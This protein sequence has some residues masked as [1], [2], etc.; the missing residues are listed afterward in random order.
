[1]LQS[2]EILGN[3]VEEI[4]ESRV[5]VT[6][7]R[8]RYYRELQFPTRPTSPDCGPTNGGLT[9]NGTIFLVESVIAGLIPT[10]GDQLNE[11]IYL[12]PLLVM[13]AIHWCMQSLGDSIALDAGNLLYLGQVGLP[14]WILTSVE[15]TR[16]KDGDLKGGAICDIGAFEY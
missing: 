6:P 11:Y 13:A 12:H 5:K 8:T 16:P 10:D 2:Q 4:I 7:F 3:I 1:M 14:V 15:I 9:S